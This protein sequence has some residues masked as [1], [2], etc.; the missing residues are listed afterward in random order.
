M[1]PAGDR[2]RQINEFKFGYNAAPS[3]KARSPSPASKICDQRDRPDGD[4]RH[5]W[6]GSAPS[7][8]S[9]GGLVRV[10]SAG[11]G[12]GAPYDHLTDVRRFAQP[13]RWDA[14]PQGGV[15]PGS[16]G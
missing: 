2:Q 12:R 7:I 11:N 10:N 14:L 9:P 5:S 3:T 4:Q 8:A 1:Q 16:F 15:M 6:T 13:R